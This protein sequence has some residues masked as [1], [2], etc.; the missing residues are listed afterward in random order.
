M[1]KI[2]LL[3]IIL[4]FA[5]ASSC[6]KL[7]PDNHTPAIDSL[8]VG[9]IAYYQF[10]NSGVDSSGKGNDIAYYSNITPTSNRVGKPNSAFSFNGINSYLM[11]RDN[12][13]LRLSNTDFTINSWIKMS[14]YNYGDFGSVIISKR[15]SGSNKGYNFSVN[16]TGPTPTGSI[17]FGPGGGLPSLYSTVLAVKNEWCMITVVYNL[18]AKKVKIYKNGIYDTEASISPIDGS[19]NADVYIGRDNPTIGANYF[20]NGSLDD[21]RIYNRAITPQL[22]QRLYVAAN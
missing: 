7:N 10:N 22:I 4:Y 17:Y 18:A 15:F 2:L 20:L 13:D 3:G 12:S 5:V 16:G 14:D 11:I 19:I 6:K 21:I 1:K 8:K 9:L